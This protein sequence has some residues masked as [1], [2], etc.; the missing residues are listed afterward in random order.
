MAKIVVVGSSSTSLINF[1]GH[2]LK[3]MVTSGHEVVACAAGDSS[4]V[5]EQLAKLGVTYRSTHLYRTGLNPIADLYSI[6]SLIRLFRSIE[7]DV[8]L[9]YTIK[10]VIYG[11]FAARLAGVRQIY[12]MITGSGYA[13]SDRDYKSKI[14]GAIAR[15][16]YRFVLKR[17]RGVFFQNPDDR[18]LFLNLHLL[19]D[20]RKAHLINGSGIA[21]DVF[22][23]KPFPREI[24]FLLIA[25]LLRDKG[26]VEYVKAAQALRQKYPNIRCKLVGIFENSPSEI[27]ETEVRAWTEEGSIEFLGAL[28]DVIL[29]WL[30][31][32][33]MSY[34]HIIVKV[35]RVRY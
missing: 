9:G 21:L 11:S 30:I 17:N 29:H 19:E 31:A 1:R 25:R 16:L 12:S 35:R 14:I 7:P 13:F 2:L 3:K 28:D 18:Q 15:A 5:K 23:P 20:E 34:H 8:V 24:S 32:P 6:F 26:I 4:A 33:S 22:V 27:R 10:P